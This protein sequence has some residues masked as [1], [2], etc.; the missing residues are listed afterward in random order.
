LPENSDSNDIEIK[1]VVQET[2][3]QLK[4]LTLQRSIG[5]YKCPTE[6]GMIVESLVNEGTM[7]H[8]RN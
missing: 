6:L 8:M 3:E 2:Q 5:H 1:D 4:T 7:L